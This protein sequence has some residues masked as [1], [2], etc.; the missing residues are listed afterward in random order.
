MPI[1]LISHHITPCDKISDV[2]KQRLI[3]AHARHEDYEEVAWLLGVVWGMVHAIV[4]RHQ[5]HCVVIA[6]SRGRVHNKRMDEE[7]A[8]TIVL[9]V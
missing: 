2:D 4:G 6:W 8:D 3:D 9:I 7:M 5:Q 1:F